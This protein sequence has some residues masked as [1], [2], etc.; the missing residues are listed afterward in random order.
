MAFVKM[1][2]GDYLNSDAVENLIR[3]IHRGACML[4]EKDRMF[5]S[6][7]CFSDEPDDVIE[8]MMQT[9]RIFDA[10]DG[11]Q[12]KHI[13]IAIGKKPNLSKKKLKKR[14]RR[15]VGFWKDRYQL[16]WGVH[17]NHPNEEKENFHIHL[18]I[19]SVN[20]INGNKVN[21]TKK[22]FRKFKKAAKRIWEHEQKAKD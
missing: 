13:V 20:M 17:H 3:Y 19:N 4:P 11:V 21:I 15:T 5:E 2:Q 12:C 14:I 10:K 7:G 16:F 6:M 18:A 8:N 22:T 1:V 9:K